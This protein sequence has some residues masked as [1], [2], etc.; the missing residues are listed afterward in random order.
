MTTSTVPNVEQILSELLERITTATEL[1]DVNIAAG[2][3]A[4]ELAGETE[5][6]A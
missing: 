3:A 6:R 4:H 2:I 5:T 1:V